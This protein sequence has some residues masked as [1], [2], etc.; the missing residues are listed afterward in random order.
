M[1]SICKYYFPVTRNVFKS[2][3]ASHK[4]KHSLRFEGR[5]AP[6]ISNY[7]GLSTNRQTKKRCHMS[8]LQLQGAK[9]EKK[10][11]KTFKQYGLF[12]WILVACNI[13]QYLLPL[14]NKSKFCCPVISHKQFVNW[15]AIRLLQTIKQR[16]FK[17]ERIC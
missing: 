15:A 2:N 5:C 13:A 16:L 14:S 9:L 3:P 11:P 1:R 7:E 4:K 8:Q 10:F 6:D 12:V 17:T